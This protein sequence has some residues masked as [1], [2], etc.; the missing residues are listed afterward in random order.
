[1]LPTTIAV[2]PGDGKLIWENDDHELHRGMRMSFREE[3]I[4]IFS[5]DGT[6]ALAVSF[7]G[8]LDVCGGR[9]SRA[10]PSAAAGRRRKRVSTRS[11]R[12]LAGV[13]EDMQNLYHEVFALLLSRT[14]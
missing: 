14:R 11:R 12:A 9:V 5:P 7:E 3:I 13:S 6:H 1:M 8:N 2:N 4:A 10:N